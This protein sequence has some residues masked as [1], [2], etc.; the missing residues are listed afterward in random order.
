M[1]VD[2]LAKIFSKTIFCDI[3]QSCIDERNYRFFIILYEYFNMHILKI[4]VQKDIPVEYD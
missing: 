3:T 2:I 1:T 4:C